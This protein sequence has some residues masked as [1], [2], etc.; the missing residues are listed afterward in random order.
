LDAEQSPALETPPRHDGNEAATPTKEQE[1]PPPAATAPARPPRCIGRDQ[2]TAK[3]VGALQAKK[4]VILVLGGG[5]IGKTTLT[6]EAATHDD[7]VRRYGHRRWFVPLETAANTEVLETSVVAAG[8][9]APATTKLDAALARLGPAPSLIVL[10][11]LE[12]PWERERLDV[13]RRL[14]QLA[15]V[16]GLCLLASIRGLEPP[17]GARWT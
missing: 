11:N 8:G 7:V 13:E 5:G 15:A 4:S 6:L 10:D 17:G 1:R 2:E 16:P 12:T 14:G 3:L 9:P